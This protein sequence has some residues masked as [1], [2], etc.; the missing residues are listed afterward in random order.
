[1]KLQDQLICL[2]RD[3]K[4]PQRELAEKAD[5]S[6]RA[7]SKL[8]SGESSPNACTI[9][10]LVEELGYTVLLV[11]KGVQMTMV[12][13]APEDREQP[14]YGFDPQFVVGG[15]IV[16]LDDIKKAEGYRG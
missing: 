1:M 10:S 15:T 12:F 16:S 11:P 13:P 14:I 5:I 7:L 4:R 2:V 6:P 9:E 8:L 3:S